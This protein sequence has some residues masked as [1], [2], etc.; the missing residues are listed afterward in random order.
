MNPYGFGSMMNGFAP[1]MLNML[2]NSMGMNAMAGGGMGGGGG[3][4]GFRKDRVDTMRGSTGGSTGF[5]PGYSG[6]SHN[7]SGTSSADAGGGG[8]AYGGHNSTAVYDQASG[9][10]NPM[11]DM[12]AYGAQMNGVWGGG[13]ATP[14]SVQAAMLQAGYSG[15][16]M[17][18]A[19]DYSQ[20]GAY[21]NQS[22]SYYGPARGTPAKSS[23][24]DTIRKGFKPY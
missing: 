2:A 6:D 1:G 23:N 22:A 11:G 20:L 3:E 7:N 13:A 19:G 17:D 21:N 24:A 16:G 8:G 9:M 15:V 4:Q 5:K 14:A 10:S 12:S 18:N